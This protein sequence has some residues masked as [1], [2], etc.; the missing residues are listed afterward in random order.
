MSVLPW[1]QALW[2]FSKSLGAG[3]MGSGVSK[4]VHR[5]ALPLGCT[6]L[7]P[8]PPKKYRINSTL[9]ADLRT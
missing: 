5:A 3:V 7:L 4:S 8:F 6:S 9:F 2:E 1:I